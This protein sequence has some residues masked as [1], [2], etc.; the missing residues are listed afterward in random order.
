MESQITKNV[1]CTY[2]G[3]NEDVDTTVFFISGNPGLISYYHPFLSLLARHLAENGEIAG[4]ETPSFRIYGCSLGGFEVS[5]PSVAGSTFKSDTKDNTGDGNSLYDL[6]EQI[7][8]VQGKLN[9]VMRSVSS[10][11]EKKQ[12]VILIGHSVG[13]YMAMEILQ[14]HREATAESSQSDVKVRGLPDFDITGGVM[15]F[16][17][18]MDIAASPS[19]Q[20]LTV[21]FF[22]GEI[23]TKLVDN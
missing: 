5:E 8:F 9:E 22:T 3:D 23:F 18:V 6:E 4:Q 7:C 1:F 15:L 10:S 12:K 11:T 2:T 14:R 19:G 21:C 17:T 13:T 20:K 16:P